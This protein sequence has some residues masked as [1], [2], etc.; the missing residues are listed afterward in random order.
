M[1]ILK[2]RVLH[3]IR[4]CDSVL[5][6]CDFVTNGDGRQEIK[7]ITNI[8]CLKNWDQFDLLDTVMDGEI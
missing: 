4:R 1:N 2:T 8:Y 5:Y 7:K 3:L 6:E